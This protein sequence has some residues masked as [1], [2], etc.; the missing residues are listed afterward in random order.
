MYGSV[1][2]MDIANQMEKKGFS[3]DRRKIVLEKPIK[4]IGEFE[5]PIKL[6]PGVTGT[7]KVVV[8]PEE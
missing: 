3:I 8:S 7:I 6:H 1:T 4:N 2:T 5:V